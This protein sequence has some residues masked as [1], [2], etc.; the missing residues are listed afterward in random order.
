MQS[1][2]MIGGPEVPPTSRY[3]VNIKNLK[4]S[5][6]KSEWYEEFYGFLRR[7]R[8]LFV[9]LYFKLKYLFC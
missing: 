1:F 9:Y 7:Y 2:R 4:T 3:E 8:N 5:D 6:M